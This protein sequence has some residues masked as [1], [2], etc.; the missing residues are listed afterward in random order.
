MDDVVDTVILFSVDFTGKCG[1]QGK[2]SY[3]SIFSS[4]NFTGV[5]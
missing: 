5:F 1:F 4:F 3:S 2:I